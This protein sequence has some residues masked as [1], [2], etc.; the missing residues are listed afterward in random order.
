MSNGFNSDCHVMHMPSVSGGSYVNIPCITLKIM[1][2]K[3]FGFLTIVLFQ[4]VI[5]VFKFEVLCALG[6]ALTK[7]WTT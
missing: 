5:Q 2:L 7:F 4:N 1:Q 6:Q 3:G